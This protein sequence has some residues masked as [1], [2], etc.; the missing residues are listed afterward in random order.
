[1]TSVVIPLYNERGALEM[2]H[3]EIAET[4]ERHDLDLEMVFV[5]DGS[6]DG[7]WETIRA[8]ARH[9]RRVRGLRLRRNFGKSAALAAGFQAARGSTIVTM[10]ADLQDDPAELPRLLARLDEGYDLVSGWKRERR[11]PW[12]RLLASR[13][14]NTVVSWGTRVRLHDHNCGFKAYRGEVVREI[15]LYGGLHRF[16]P[17]LAHARGFKVTEM[18]V[19]HRAR[20]FGSSKYGA[21]RLVTGLMDFLGVMFVS[22]FAGRPHHLLGALGLV[23]LAA[24]LGGGAMLGLFWA[25]RSAEAEVAAFSHSPLFVYVAAGLVLGTQLIAL[26]LLAELLSAHLRRDEDLYSVAERV[27]EPVPRS[28]ALDAANCSPR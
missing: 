2:L 26:G 22:G 18:P 21:G 28:S 25:F 1:M 7:A 27:G 12:Q 17:A 24:A 11:D 4:A 5:D 8:L 20:P 13:V 23:S 15:R 6:A 14:F 9:D 16:V 10:D 19:H 3:R